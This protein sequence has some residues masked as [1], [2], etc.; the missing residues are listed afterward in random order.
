MVQKCMM[1]EFVFKNDSSIAPIPFDDEI[2]KE[3]STKKHLKIGFLKYEGTFYPCKS[4]I[5]AMDKSIKLLKEAGH[6]LIELDHEKFSKIQIALAKVL[7]GNDGQAE[8]CLN[9]EAIVDQYGLAA[10]PEMIPKFIKPFLSK[11][12]NLI[13]LKREGL[14]LQHVGNSDMLTYVEGC[15]E[16]QLLCEENMWYWKE[17]GLDCMIMPT[18]ALPAI[19]LGHS[20]ELIPMTTY[21][22]FINALDYPSGNIPNVVKVTHEHLEEPYNDPKYPDD[23]T[24]MKARETLEGSAGLPM[25]IQVIT[26]RG[27][28]EKCLGIMKQVDKIIHS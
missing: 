14:I 7:L 2:V 4:A 8:D 20:K 5:A 25:S 1:S 6:E 3:Y 28:E 11:V 13:G 19:K 17:K 26:M 23:E 21:S 10:L 15:L 24:V 9:G 16:K 27:N 22:A 18:T 12:L